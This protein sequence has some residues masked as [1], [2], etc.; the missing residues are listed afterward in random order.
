MAPSLAKSIG[1]MPLPMDEIR[2]WRFVLTS[3]ETGNTRATGAVGRGPCPLYAT[4]LIADARVPMC[5]RAWLNA[6][7]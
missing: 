3:M 2:Y 1:E 4:V 5:E 7:L 6:G